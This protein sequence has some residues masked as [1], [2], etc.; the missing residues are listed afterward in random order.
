MSLAFG[1]LLRVQHGLSLHVSDY[2][3]DPALGLAAT[4][5]QYGVR[6]P[7]P[8]PALRLYDEPPAQTP[9][10]YRFGDVSIS[11][12]GT[13]RTPHYVI[14]QDLEAYADVVQGRA[15]A[16]VMAEVIERSLAP[17]DEAGEPIF[18]S[19]ALQL[20]ESD[21][22]HSES[23]ITVIDMVPTSWQVSTALEGRVY[24]AQITYQITATATPP[25]A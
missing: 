3:Q 24:L 21:G 9:S 25:A 17:R 10:Y 2:L 19:D 7:D 13:A 11:S 22:S 23:D 8:M 14:D 1:V 18:A 6:P 5:G 15:L 16:V 12:Y 20:R 4:L